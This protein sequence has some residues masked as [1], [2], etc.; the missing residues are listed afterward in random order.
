VRFQP[1]EGARP[2]DLVVGNQLFRQTRLE[3][4]ENRAIPVGVK[5]RTMRLGS[6]APSPVRRLSQPSRVTGSATV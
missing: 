3:D 2:T 6:E 5:V 4:V 1:V